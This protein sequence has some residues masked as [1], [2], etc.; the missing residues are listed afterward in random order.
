MCPPLVE[1]TMNMCCGITYSVVALKL[2]FMILL[3]L[4]FILEGFGAFVI[5]NLYPV[6]VLFIHWIKSCTAYS[7]NI[8]SISIMFSLY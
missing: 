5:L 4:W 6:W 2:N 8:L 1:R 3:E 7:N